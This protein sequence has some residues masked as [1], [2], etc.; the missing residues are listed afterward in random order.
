MAEKVAVL[1]T[2]DGDRRGVFAGLTDQDLNEV[3]KTGLIRLDEARNC[4]YWHQSIGGVFGLS[5]S[6]PNDQCRIGEKV[7]NL[8]LNG[9]TSVATL[10]PEAAK[11][12]KEAAVYGK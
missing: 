3:I 9:V 6:G 2:T 7:E 12:W 4:I 11:A 5:K 10:T 8:Y 1:V